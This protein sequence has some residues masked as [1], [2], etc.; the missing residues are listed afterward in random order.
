[1]KMA[2]KSHMAIAYQH[3]GMACNGGVMAA[4]AKKAGQHAKAW[5]QK[6]TTVW[7]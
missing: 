7:A 2:Q 4:A 1:M 6:K 3:N 5:H